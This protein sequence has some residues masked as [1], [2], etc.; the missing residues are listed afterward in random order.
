VPPMT[1]ADRE[2]RLFRADIFNALKP[3]LKLGPIRPPT[4]PTPPGDGKMG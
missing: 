2:R 1:D 3:E 4:R